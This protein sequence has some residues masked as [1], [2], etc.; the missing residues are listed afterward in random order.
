MPRFS[1]AYG[2]FEQQKVHFW[3]LWVSINHKRKREGND[4]GRNSWLYQAVKLGITDIYLSN[5]FCNKI[6]CSEIKKKKL[7]VHFLVLRVSINNKGEMR[8]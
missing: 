2:N 7:S 6:F 4:I 1:E 8:G 5:I 3:V